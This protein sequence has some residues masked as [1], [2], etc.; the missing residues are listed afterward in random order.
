MIRIAR[1]EGFGVG[2]WSDKQKGTSKQPFIEGGGGGGRRLAKEAKLTGG[3][4]RKERG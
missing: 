1:G 2:L 4:E 3:R